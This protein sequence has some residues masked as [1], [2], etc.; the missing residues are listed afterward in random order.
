MLGFTNLGLNEQPLMRVD[1]CGADDAFVL[2]ERGEPEP[3]VLLQRQLEA[4]H[5]LGVVQH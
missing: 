5:Y 1:A 4:V 2:D 3:F